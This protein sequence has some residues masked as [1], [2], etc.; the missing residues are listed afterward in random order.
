MQYAVRGVVKVKKVRVLHSCAN[1][2]ARATLVPMTQVP[3]LANL[4]LGT[5][6]AGKGKGKEAKPITQQEENDSKRY[7]DIFVKC[8]KL[9]LEKFSVNRLETADQ[10]KA[11]LFGLAKV[12]YLNECVQHWF[13]VERADNARSWVQIMWNWHHTILKIVRYED[14]GTFL[15]ELGLTPWDPPT[16]PLTM[17]NAISDKMNQVANRLFER[18]VVLDSDDMMN[19]PRHAKRLMLQTKEALREVLFDTEATDNFLVQSKD[20]W[21]D[22]EERVAASKLTMEEFDR[23]LDLEE[24]EK[25]ALPLCIRPPTRP[26]YVISSAEEHKEEEFE[27][28][29]RDSSDGERNP[30][31]DGLPLTLTRMSQLRT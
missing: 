4:N 23:R 18:L 1:A 30:P 20:Y 16:Y 11:F 9:V 22:L 31:D 3:N 2:Q 7:R 19:D 26:G 8:R 13:R 29:Q 5:P 28:E 17:E 24:Q 21:L 27:W 15:L 12:E 10:I 6:R 14:S 25:C